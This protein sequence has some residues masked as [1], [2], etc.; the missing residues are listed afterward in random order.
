MTENPSGTYVGSYT[1]KAGDNVTD[2]TVT[3]MLTDALGNEGTDA[4]QKVTIDT[5]AEITSVTVAG[6]PANAGDAITVTMVGE[7]NGTATF[8]IA[9]VTDATDV[10]M[11]E[12]PSGTYVGSYTAQEGDKA[13]NATVTV[14]LIDAVDNEGINATQKVT[15]ITVTEF[16]LMLESGINVIA[17]PLADAIA[18]GATEPIT[19]VKD[20]GDALGDAWSLIISYDTET[21]KFQ[22]Y[23]PGTPD[24][25]NSNVEI[26]GDTGLIVVMKPNQSKTLKLRGKGW[27]PGDIALNEGINLIGIPL[28]DATVEGGIEPITMVKDLGDALGDAWS[29]IVS[30]DTETS[31]FQSYAPGTPDDAK[32][33]ITIDGGVGLIL[34]MKSATSI[35][36]TGEPWSNPPLVAP[37]REQLFMLDQTISPILELDGAIEV[38]GLSV[39]ARNLS[40]GAVM[41]DTT[42]LN[43]GDG[44]FSITFA[45]F[46][47][48]QA[49]KVGDVFEVSFSD[50]NGKIEVDSIRY[51]VTERDLQLGRIALGDL[52]AYAIPRRTELL[53]NWPNPFNPET[54][55]PF[56]LKE[57]SDIAITIYDINGRVVRTLELGRV[58]AGIYQTKSKA[59]YWDGT[60]DVGEHVA[61]GIYFYRLQAGN[62]S[63]L[64]SMI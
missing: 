60:N 5:V 18:E 22:S 26:M 38:D 20:L 13:E 59:V 30:Y 23:T 56:K 4:T 51:T 42:G 39:T 36:I 1:A 16:D 28:A 11:T 6:S 45:D 62:F 57:S 7:A 49:A 46:V 58:P 10:A 8:S 17:I 21:S 55:I 24:D 64:L 15:I 40:S 14:K 29:L 32:S 54:W 53:Q 3:A 27:E 9:G 12:E 63:A 61:S 43:A 25:A 41:T 44:R 48:N 2:A 33:N 34:V 50:P 31:K 19:M 52:V 47:T 37:M 35:S